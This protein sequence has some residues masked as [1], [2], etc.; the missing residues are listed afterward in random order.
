[1]NFAASGACD[2]KLL[3]KRKTGVREMF[4]SQQ[5]HMSC[6]S[7]A[8][9][10]TCYGHMDGL[11]TR[12]L[13]WQFQFTSENRDMNAWPTAAE[14]RQDISSPVRNLTRLTILN[15]LIP[16][17]EYNVS[18]WC[19]RLDI[20][21]GATQY[22]VTLPVG[23]YTSGGNLSTAL[24]AAIIA[25]D[26]ALAA[27]VTSYDALTDKITIASGGPVFS[28]LFGTGAFNNTSLWKVLGFPRVDTV[29]AATQTSAGRINLHGVQVLDIFINEL[30]NSLQ[31]PV[32][33]ILLKP[34]DDT[35]FYHEMEIVP[36]HEFAPISRLTFLT[37]RFLVPYQTINSL[38]QTSADYRSYDF[39]GFNV[40]LT[41]GFQV[42][43]LT[44]GQTPMLST[45]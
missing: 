42:A 20:L 11:H 10:M 37:F 22:N 4:I 5:T 12:K 26:A 18:S 3:V 40:Y 28:L 7:C 32:A 44:N 34:N 21:L 33:R 30:T 19:N 13:W 15:S 43:E 38:G 17:K 6:R 16:L 8:K 24:T 36:T 9:G 2:I 23:E 27:F 14:W 41:L 45:S 1:M 29:A 25:T 31:A 39:N 35:T